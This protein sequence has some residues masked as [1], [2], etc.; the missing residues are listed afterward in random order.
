LQK[1]NYQAKNHDAGVVCLNSEFERTHYPDV[2]ARE[3]LAEKIG[4]PEARI[5]V[6]ELLVHNKFIYI[7]EARPKA[8][9]INLYLNN[10][11]A[12]EAFA[13]QSDYS[14]AL[15]HIHSYVCGL[16][17]LLPFCGCV[18]IV[19]FVADIKVAKFL[20]KSA[21]AL[22]KKRWNK[23]ANLHGAFLKKNL[24]SKIPRFDSD[25]KL[26]FVICMT[27]GA[28]VARTEQKSSFPI[29]ILE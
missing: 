12:R 4:L 28:C 2:F 14:E 16:F 8:R 11:F 7:R 5:Q 19:R 17:R 15:I 26:F 22:F 6:S 25:E 23:K 21:S 29:N 10:P 18:R 20:S 24:I 27:R 9:P 13:L 1:P 3:R